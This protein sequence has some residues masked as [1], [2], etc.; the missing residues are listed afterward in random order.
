MKMQAILQLDELEVA[1]KEYVKAQGFPID[2]MDLDITLTKG[3]GENGTYATVDFSPAGSAPA[4]PPV[5]TLIKRG[6]TEVAE[7]TVDAPEEE[8]IPEVPVEDS[9]EEEVTPHTSLFNK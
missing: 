8:S 1:I 4:S 9:T 3:R 6:T 2:G 5:D 7:E